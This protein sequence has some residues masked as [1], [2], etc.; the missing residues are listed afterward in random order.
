[1]SNVSQAMKYLDV[2]L[3][4]MSKNSTIDSLKILNLEIF[5]FVRA[6]AHGVANDSRLQRNMA[7]GWQMT[8]D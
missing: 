7:R 5:V 2:V 6:A 4:L 1:M 8:A 3:L